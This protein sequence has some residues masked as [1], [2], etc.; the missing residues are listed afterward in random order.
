MYQFTWGGFCDWYLEF[1]KPV[2]T[3]TDEAAKAET[4]ATTAFVLTEILKLL[5][6]VMP[7]ITEELWE[8]FRPGGP[9]MLMLTAWPEYK[10]PRDD[11][12][13]T[14]MN[15]VVQAISEI[16]TLRC[17]DERAAGRED[18]PVLQGRQRGRR[19]APQAPRRH[20]P[21]PRASRAHRWRRRGAREGRGAN[22]RTRGDTAACRWPA[23]S[24]PARSARA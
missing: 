5:H 13:A 12:A 4:R 1:T 22:R 23:S 14:E 3:G 18:E 16:R 6:P 9:D 10:M 20:H 17:R 11:A 24:M 7:F 15:W 19:R 21:D 8:K 2:L